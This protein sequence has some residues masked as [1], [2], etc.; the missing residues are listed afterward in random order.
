[1]HANALNLLL[2]IYLA[3]AGSIAHIRLELRIAELGVVAQ[4]LEHKLTL[5][6]PA[7]L[8]VQAITFHS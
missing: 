3:D 1:M 8:I 6:I 4:V 2:I 5:R 7:T